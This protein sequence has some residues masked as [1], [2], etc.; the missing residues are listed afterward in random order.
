MER[1]HLR[2]WGNA[3]GLWIL[4]KF[5]GR[6]FRSGQTRYNTDRKYHYRRAVDF[7]SCATR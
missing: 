1:F 4:W 6:R 3:G 5:L 2:N 7:P